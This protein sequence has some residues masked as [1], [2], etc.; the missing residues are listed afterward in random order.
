MSEVNARDLRI[1]NGAKDILQTYHGVGAQAKA[2]IEIELCFFD[3]KSANLAPMNVAQNHAL[4]KAANEALG[5]EFARNE[6]TADMLE[7]GTIAA[8]PKELAHILADAQ[9]KISVLV[10]EAQRAGLKRSYFQE[11]PEKTDKDLLA[12]LMDI[13]RYKAFFGPPRADMVGVAA[14]FSV[15]K[16]NQV[17]VSYR[18]PDH[19]LSDVRRLYSLAPFLFMLSDNSCGF[20]MG[21]SFAGH[22]AM[23]HR[24]SLGARGG[25]PPYVFTAQS[26]EEYVAEHIKHVMNNPL[27]VYYNEMGE[28]VRLPSGTWT[29]FHELKERGL[30]TA[31]NYYFSESILWPDVKIAALKNAAG[32]VKGHRY[33]ARMFGV[34]A[35]QHQSALLIV[36]G[37]AFNAEFAAKTDALLAK[38]GFSGQDLDGALRHVE[39]AYKA[40]LHHNGAFFD[41]AYGSGQLIDFSRKFAGLL[42]E[43]YAGSTL[44]QAL[45]PALYICRTGCSDAKVNRV[46]FDTLDKVKDHQRAYDPM[47]LNNPN[48]C[49]A[50]IFGHGEYK[51]LLTE[52][53]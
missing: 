38:F 2:G 3:P 26:G 37:L 13:P 4:R 34:G 27:F 32:E 44:E 20:D 30:N 10:A 6:P 48:S 35:H 19:M 42:E 22:S 24:A 11:L 31:T 41:I 9:D 47:I 23:H 46:L 14:Y 52:C 7:I 33:E 36:A 12:G 49:A 43:A 40:A 28:L 21:Q 5:T 29:S 1:I 53:V 45:A 8:G 25:V 17:S 39:Q 51:A 18:D 50:M 15:C 16:S